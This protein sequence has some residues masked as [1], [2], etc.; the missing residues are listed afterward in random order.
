MELN[1]QEICATFD[2][3]VEEGIVI[4]N[5]YRAVLHSEQSFQVNYL[6]S[7]QP[8]SL[9]VKAKLRSF[10][11]EFRVLSGLAHKPVTPGTEPS[12]NPTSASNPPSSTSSSASSTS[13]YGLRPGSDID[14]S[15]YEITLLPPRHILAFNK[16]SAARPHVLILTEDGHRR[17]YEP[18]DIGDIQALRSVLS[19]L[20]KTG[21][22]RYLGIYNCGVDSGCSRL[23]KHLQVFPAPELPELESQTQGEGEG[24]GFSLWPDS[25][26]EDEDQLKNLPMKCFVKKF[27][28]ADEF[29]GEDEILQAYTELLEKATQA[30][31]QATRKGGVDI[32]IAK[33]GVIPH[34][35][36]LDKKWMVVVP[37]RNAGLHGLVPNAAAIL[38]MV[39]VPNEKQ[40]KAWMGEGVSRVLAHAG[41][42][43][44]Q[45]QQV[46]E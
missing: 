20:V 27:D 13:S 28:Q 9:E 1:E 18:L 8:N 38:G 37:R 2:Q 30:L 25:M 26:G 19:S 32:A 33:E 46:S 12:P 42:P 39:W 44:G 11:I 3:R 21:E 5:G 15:G 29:P 34:N 10:Q 17:Q 14:I 40:L 23:H 31:T 43:Q 7:L 41:I 24:K 36:I 6:P 16:F 45:E 35:V 22:T 4:F